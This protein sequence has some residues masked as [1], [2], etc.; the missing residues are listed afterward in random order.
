MDVERVEETSGVTLVSEE[1]KEIMTKVMIE[2][3]WPRGAA[4]HRIRCERS[5]TL[6][7][8]ATAEH[9]SNRPRVYVS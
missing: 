5:F 6:R 7:S 8:P 2:I 1:S 4:R 9:L 3:L